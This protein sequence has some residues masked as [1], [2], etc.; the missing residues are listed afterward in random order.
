MLGRLLG[1]LGHAFA[2][3]LPLLVFAI[4]HS[5]AQRHATDLSRRQSCTS[6]IR[7]GLRLMLCHRRHD[8]Q[9]KAVGLWHICRRDL[10]TGL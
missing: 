5:P 7:Y 8:V 4:R 1:I 3:C 6:A 9:Q 2:G 10:D